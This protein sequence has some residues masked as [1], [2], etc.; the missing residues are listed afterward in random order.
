MRPLRQATG[1]SHF[2][3]VFLTDVRIPADN[4]VGAVNG[5]WG[6]IMTTLTNERTMIGTGVGR[7]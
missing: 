5:G 3:E 7:R 6:V 4:V 1:A 2:N